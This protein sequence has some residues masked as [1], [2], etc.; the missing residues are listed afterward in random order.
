MGDPEA[1]DRALAAERLA[2]AREARVAGRRE[3]AEA[4][5]RQAL[6]L[7]PEDAT[8]HAELG[9]QYLI[10]GRNA[11]AVAPLRRAAALAP[12]SWRA[13]AWLGVA[14]RQQDP[15]GALIAHRRAIALRP[16]DGGLHSNMGNVLLDLGRHEAAVEALTRAIE[17]TPGPALSWMNLGFALFH[18]GRHEEAVAA[19]DGALARDSSMAKA[20]FGRGGAHM[21]L[22]RWADALA[23]YEAALRLDARDAL[24]HLGRA[25]ALVE[26]DFLRPVVSETNQA[27]LESFDRAIALKPDLAEARWSR[28]LTRLRLGRFA[29]GWDDY[30]RRWDAP[31]FV[32]R[33]A[34]QVSAPL[35]QRLARSLTRE[36]LAGQR[37]LLVAEQGVGDV[38][39][40]ASMIP[41]VLGI[42]GSVALICETRLHRL[43]AASFAGLELHPP[44]AMPDA[45][46]VLAI[47]SLGRLFRQKAADIPGRPYLRPSN[48]ARRLWADRLGPTAGRLRV[49]VSWRGG[50][51]HTGGSARSLALPQLAPVLDLEGCEFFSIQY[52]DVVADLETWN[53]AGSHPVL[54]PPGDVEDFEDLAALLA[55]LDVVV[56]VQTAVV[57][58][59]GAVGR[60]CLT[61]VPRLPEWR[62]G[63]FGDRM[64]WYGS[65]RLFRQPADGD[66][67]SALSLVRREVAA[68]A[69]QI[70]GAR[71]EDLSV[72]P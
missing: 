32:S 44:G 64:P 63:V 39:M 6:Q 2:Q 16:H 34:G 50:V 43:F 35:R 36:D 62:Y 20:F 1:G 10:A 24:S 53:G 31:S 69:R 7:A 67:T 66:W 61:L 51:A 59:A 17:L 30:E 3:E 71:A 65:V 57:H 28:S 19:F 5:C 58:L 40:F 23:D 29:D 4:L 60:P 56:S 42:A 27:A 15:T 72:S 21:A 37:V 38:L 55:N 26:L 46:V 70:M 54:L 48:E 52:G 18:A 12:D 13:H 33:S 11:E 45:D 9:L 49:G 8:A 47:G 25:R 68:R 14:L 41:D 22:R